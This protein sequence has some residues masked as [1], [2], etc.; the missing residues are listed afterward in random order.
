[1][2]LRGGDMISTFMAA[3]AL[4]SSAHGGGDE[5][6][7]AMI[8]GRTLD[9][10]AVAADDPAEEAR[11]LAEQAVNDIIADGKERDARLQFCQSIPNM[12][13]DWTEEI[14]RQN[15]R[16]VPLGSKGEVAEL[17]MFYLQGYVDYAE[18]SLRERY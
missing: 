13:A 12:K 16:G 14:D 3:L 4:A 10:A 15:A 18:K 2:I 11:A 5:P 1:M 17:C 9:K 7:S 6:D 8:A